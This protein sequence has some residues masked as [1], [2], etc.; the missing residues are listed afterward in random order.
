MPVPVAVKFA[1]VPL[2]QNVWAGLPEGAAETLMVAVTERRM[3]D[4]Q[5]PIVWLA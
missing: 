4:S 2:L 1:T 3:A 5:L